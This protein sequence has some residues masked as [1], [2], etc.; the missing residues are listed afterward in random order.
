MCENNYSNFF[1]P[2]HKKREKRR[3]APKPNMN[4]SLESLKTSIILF[5]ANLMSL[6]IFESRMDDVPSRLI[7]SP[8]PHAQDAP[9]PVPAHWL[10]LYGGRPFY[11]WSGGISAA[12]VVL[13]GVVGV[14]DVA[15]ILILAV[16]EKAEDAATTV[17]VACWR[18]WLQGL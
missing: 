14:Q 9:T 15:A 17:A 2:R 1:I 4:E 3:Q 13:L 10:I 11:H 8:R 6:I 18:P 7:L 16:P 12:M 5:P